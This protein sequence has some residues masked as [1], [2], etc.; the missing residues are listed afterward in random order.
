MKY[1]FI[2]T[3]RSIKNVAIYYKSTDEPVHT[4]H[5][6]KMKGQIVI[7]G[8]TAADKEMRNTRIEIYPF[9][10]D[11]HDYIYRSHTFGKAYAAS[12]FL[13]MVPCY[14]KLCQKNYT[15]KITEIFDDAECTYTSDISIESIVY[16]SKKEIEKA[17]T[18]AARNVNVTIGS[19]Y[20][21]M[22]IINTGVVFT[23]DPTVETFARDKSVSESIGEYLTAVAD[24]LQ[25]SSGYMRSIV[26]CCDKCFKAFSKISLANNMVIEL[27][28]K[29]CCDDGAMVTIDA[30]I[31]DTIK[32]LN[33]VGYHTEFCCGSHEWNS[34]MYIKFKNTDILLIDWIS[35]HH[36]IEGF[37]IEKYA[38]S[39]RIDSEYYRNLKIELGFAQARAMMIKRLEDALVEY[40]KEYKNAESNIVSIEAR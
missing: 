15:I 12:M 6:E 30:E 32:H 34:D 13:Q 18:K 8:T 38:C 16:A 4:L 2:T 11:I 31:Y 27:P 19:D 39:I 21:K 35:K 3:P 7:E 10:N 37:D 22:E 25:D 9:I 29:K 1:T 17:V 33:D 20:L 24:A 36:N 40:M 23:V 26:I 28:Y 14:L 5:V